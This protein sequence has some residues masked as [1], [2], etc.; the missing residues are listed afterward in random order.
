MSRFPTPDGSCPGPGCARPPPVRAPKTR[1]GR[2]ARA[3]PT[4]AAPAPRP[5][6]APPEPTPS[7][8]SGTAGS[9][10][11]A[12]RRKARSPSARSI[13]VIIWHLLNDPAARFTDL[14]PDYYASPHDT[15]PQDPATTSAS[16]RP[17]ATTSPSPPARKQPDTDRLTAC[18]PRGPAATGPS[19][20]APNPGH[21]SGLRWFYFRSDH[22]RAMCQRAQFWR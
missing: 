6:S 16:S 7:S 8:A 10:A 15:R 5:P 18:R 4:S 20:H 3:T 9:P 11:A 13:L 19:R 12:A 2:R 14:G 22:T 1:P 21:V 17:S